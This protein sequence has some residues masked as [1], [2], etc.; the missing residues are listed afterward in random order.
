MAD[1]P[2]LSVVGLSAAFATEQGIVSVVD[3]VSF[4]LSAGATLGLVGESGCGK[5]VTALSI[6]GLLPKPAG[7]VTGGR[8]LFKGEDLLALSAEQYQRIRGNRIAM[9][10]QEPTTALNPVHRIGRQLIET[11]DMH[12]PELS[13]REKTAA[14]V[15]LLDRV[16]IPAPDQRLR[17]YPHQLSGGMRQRVLIAIAL[18]CRP[19]VLIADEPTTALDVTIQAQILELMRE[20]QREY[21]M[22]ILF[23]THDLGVVAELCDEVVVMYAGRVVERAGVAALFANPRHPYSEGLLASIPRLESVP[24]T[25]LVTIPGMVPA[26]SDMPDGCRF[27]NRCSRASNRCQVEPPLVAAGAGRVV[28]CHHATGVDE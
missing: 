17:D 20:L 19:D 16:G 8:I 9:I 5:S 18:A 26:L 25:R 23:I 6:M 21:G 22:G 24:K 2:I 28:A 3:G 12:R 14:A 1:L 7:R 11:L 15:E 10:F 13:K 4:D 27:R